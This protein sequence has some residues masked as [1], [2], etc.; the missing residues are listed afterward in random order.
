MA[1]SLETL[2]GTNITSIWGR[3]LGL[4][5]DE[6][7]AGAKELKLAVEDIV[8][9]VPTTALAYGVTRILTSGSSQGPV[10]HNLPAPIPGVRKIIV[11]NTTSTG[12]YQFL[13]T[14]NGAAILAAS[15]GTTKGLVNFIGQ[16]GVMQLVGLTTAIWAVTAQNSTGGITYTTST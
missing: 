6:T 14:G 15:D 13:S 3:R 8:S 12:S 10:Q 1:Q 16:G 11:M 2:R 7:I 5:F 9:T 4:Q